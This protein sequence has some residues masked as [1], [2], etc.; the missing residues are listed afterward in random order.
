MP[1][2][3]CFATARETAEFIVAFGSLAADNHDTW[4]LSDS[5]YIVEHVSSTS[6]SMVN[7]DK[8]RDQL[9]IDETAV[10]LARHADALGRHLPLRTALSLPRPQGVA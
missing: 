5:H 10:E 2:T 7:L 4:L 9:A 3:G 1:P 6:A 8:A